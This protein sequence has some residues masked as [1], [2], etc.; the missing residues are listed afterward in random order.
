M[1]SAADAAADAGQPMLYAFYNIF[2]FSRFRHIATLPDAI[3]PCHYALLMHDFRLPP[4]LMLAM[5]RY[6]C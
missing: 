6:R 5:I 3:L 1:L 4:Q 2:A